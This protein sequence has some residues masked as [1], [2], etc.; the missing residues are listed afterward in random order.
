MLRMASEKKAQNGFARLGVEPTPLR[1]DSEDVACRR[2]SGHRSEWVCSAHKRL[3]EIGTTQKGSKIGVHT[4]NGF[5]TDWKKRSMPFRID[6]EETTHNGLRIRVTLLR[7]HSKRTL[8][9]LH[10]L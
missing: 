5:E 9:R 6:S 8:R 3:E 1:T 2:R 4:Q 10:M 7:S